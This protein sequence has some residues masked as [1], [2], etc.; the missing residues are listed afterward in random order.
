MENIFDMQEEIAS[1]VVG[2]LKL[3]LFDHQIT[4]N[5][6]SPEVYNLI[7]MANH[8]TDRRGQEDL[9]KAIQI[10]EQALAIDSLDAMAWA[11]LSYAYMAHVAERYKSPEEA[12]PKALAASVHAIKLDDNCAQAHSSLGILKLFFEWDWEGARKELTRALELDP[13]NISA[14][15]TLG[16]LHSVFGN[17]P[18]CFRLLNESISR[19]PLQPTT[20]ANLIL[21]QIDADQMEEAIKTLE[22]YKHIVSGTYGES[23]YY[24]YSALIYVLQNKPDLALKTIESA[25]PDPRSRVEFIRTLAYHLLGNKKLS[26]ENLQ[27]Y[28]ERQPRGGG[29]I[30]RLYA[31][32]NEK[33][34]AFRWIATGIE[35]KHL[36]LNDLKISRLFDNIRN[37]PRY[38]EALKKMN[39]PP[40]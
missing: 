3:R 19:D 6:S 12:Y 28:I 5:R 38:L 25:T 4:A 16:V 20:Y 34:L 30:A 22:T 13:A 27:R 1:A 31:F 11:C 33:D 23:H 14:L 26:D 36:G 37:D 24:F 17:F 35:K 21:Y 40:D 2:E 32:R 7:L 15:R 39:L 8:L 10:Y 18:E 29:V 9:E